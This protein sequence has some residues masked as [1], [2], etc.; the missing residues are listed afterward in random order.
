MPNRILVKTTIGQVADDWHVGRFSL[1][2]DHLRSLK[3]ASGGPV[4]RSICVSPSRSLAW[5]VRFRI[6][7][8]TISAIT[9]GTRERGVRAS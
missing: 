1:L 9:T 3:D 2:T 8:F 4:R 5:A 7:V 6:P